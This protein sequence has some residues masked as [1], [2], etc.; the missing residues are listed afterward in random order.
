MSYAILK[1]AHLGFALLAMLMYLFRG[2]LFIRQ[3]PLLYAKW[4]NGVA[5]LI[6]TGLVAFGIWLAVLSGQWDQAW[7]ITKV[8]V[9]IGVILLGRM[10]FRADSP[11]PRSRRISLWGM[12]CILLIMVFAIVSYHLAQSQLSSPGVS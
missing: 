2:V 4:C 7:L 10:A 9:F 11:I 8:A 5:H 3:S 1:H 6:Y 12:G